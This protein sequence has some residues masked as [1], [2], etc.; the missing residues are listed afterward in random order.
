MRLRKNGIKYCSEVCKNEA[1][2]RGGTNFGFRNEGKSGKSN[3]YIRIQVNKVRVKEHR[4]IMENHLGRKLEKDE[5][6]HHINGNEKDNRI[7]NLQVLSPSEHSRL[8][9]SKKSD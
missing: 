6:V 7:E 2:R 9:K 1:M 8:H 5:H 3:P 4:Y